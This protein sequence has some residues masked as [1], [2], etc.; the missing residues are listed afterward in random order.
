MPPA[1]AAPK[2]VRVNFGVDP[3]A[4]SFERLP[5]GLQH[6]QLECTVQVFSAKGKLVRGVATTVKAA[7]KPDSFSKVMQD[8][9]PCQQA[10]DLD[11]GNYYLRLG[12]RDTRTGLIGTTN[13]KVAVASAAPSK[14]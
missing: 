14:P 11:P 4:I 10:I 12:V 7:L 3:H 5:D 6:A 8:T 2:T 13:A 1:E 9:F